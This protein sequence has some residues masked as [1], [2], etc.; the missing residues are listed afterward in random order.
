MPRD[1]LS[2]VVDWL[3]LEIHEQLPRE[4]REKLVQLADEVKK[5]T[6]IS[7]TDAPQSQPSSADQTVI[8]CEEGTIAAKQSSA[9]L[10]ARGEVMRAVG[11]VDCTM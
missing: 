11:C 6:E 2:V 8:R 4:A 10:P 1:V 3:F 9:D 7:T 5:L